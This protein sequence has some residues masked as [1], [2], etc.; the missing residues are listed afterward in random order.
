VP[1]NRCFL[2]QNSGLP[3]KQKGRSSAA[4]LPKQPSTDTCASSPPRYF[5]SPLFNAARAFSTIAAEVVDT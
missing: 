4:C 5:A 1:H 3:I 2:L